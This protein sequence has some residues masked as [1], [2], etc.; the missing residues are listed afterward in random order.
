MIG[1]RFREAL[2]VG[3]FAFAAHIVADLQLL[4]DER[5]SP[6]EFSVRTFCL[7]LFITVAWFT[8]RTLQSRVR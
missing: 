6:I 1:A 8:F 3:F 2:L 5:V 4:Q 7:V